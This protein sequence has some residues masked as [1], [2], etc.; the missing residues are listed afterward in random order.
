MRAYFRAHHADLLD[1]IRD[2][3]TLPDGDKLASALRSFTDSFD[4]G[5]GD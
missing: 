4:T 1:G 5:K 2:S 3:G